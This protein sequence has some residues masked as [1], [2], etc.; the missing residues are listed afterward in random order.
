MIRTTLA[1][2]ALV[3]ASTVPARAQWGGP[4]PT[5]TCTTTTSVAAAPARLAAFVAH[6]PLRAHVGSDGWGEI[7]TSD[8]AQFTLRTSDTDQQSNDTGLFTGDVRMSPSDDPDP[9]PV[10]VSLDYSNGMPLPLVLSNKNRSV[11]FTCK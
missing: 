9:D 1:S 10:Y 7:V 3:I 8:G 5:V 2:V 6:Q 4:T 11:T